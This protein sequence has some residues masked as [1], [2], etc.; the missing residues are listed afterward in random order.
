MTV[1]Y[2]LYIYTWLILFGACIGSFIN[3]VVYRLPKGNFLS[4]ARSYCPA[5]RKQLRWFDLIPVV[6]WLLLKGRCRYCNARISPRYPLVEAACALLAVL[7]FARFGLE[8]RTVLSFGV[9]VILL[10]VALIDL[11]TM[12]IPNQLVLALIPFAACAMLGWRD[13]SFA[14][15]AIGFITVS[16]PMLLLTLAIREAFGG[17][18]IKLMAVCGFLLGWRNTLLAFFVAIL[19]GGGYASFLLLS[20]KSKRGEHI[21]FG[22]YLCFGVAVALFWGAEIIHWYWNL[23]TY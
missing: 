10:A 8:L 21:A 19:T 14:E 9:S 17:G 11:D 15:R 3:V 18:D 23:F 4:E 6:S 22:P 5:C 12:E 16:L 1:Y 2:M 13:I 7:C 20:G